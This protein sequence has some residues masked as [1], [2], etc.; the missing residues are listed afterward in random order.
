MEIKIL[1]KDS[2]PTK[3]I[4]LKEGYF[5]IELPR[6]FFEGNPKSFKVEWIDFYR[7]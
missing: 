6:K 3:T 1:D 5:E 2:E 4:P 7:N